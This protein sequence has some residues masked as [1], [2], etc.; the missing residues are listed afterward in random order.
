MESL[1]LKSRLKLVKCPVCVVDMEPE[2]EKLSNGTFIFHTCPNCYKIV[3][4]VQ[5]E[6]E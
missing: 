4:E 6:Y 3:E 2:V 1:E 5:E